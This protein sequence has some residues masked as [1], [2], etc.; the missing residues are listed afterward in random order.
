MWWFWAHALDGPFILW[1]FIVPAAVITAAVLT[2]YACRR[3]RLAVFLAPLAVLA[4]CT[5]GASVSGHMGSSKVIAFCEQLIVRVPDSVRPAGSTPDLT[6]RA[7]GN[8]PHCRIL[9]QTWGT[10]EMGVY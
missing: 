1:C 10:W 5:A 9:D 8:Q 4:T 6:S 3:S 7:A 2:A